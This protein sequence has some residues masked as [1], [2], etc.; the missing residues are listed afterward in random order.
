MIRKL[1]EEIW[2]PHLPPLQKDAHSIQTN[3]TVAGNAD[4]YPRS[5]R[6]F[7]F[8]GVELERGTYTA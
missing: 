6:S 3:G 1:I 8:K 4:T 2:G 5:Q 7:E